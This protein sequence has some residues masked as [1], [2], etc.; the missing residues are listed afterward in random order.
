PHVG[1]A[2]LQH[3]LLAHRLWRIRSRPCVGGIFFAALRGANYRVNPCAGL[4]SNA[5]IAHMDLARTT[6]R[7][8]YNPSERINLS[9]RSCRTGREFCAACTF[10]WRKPRDVLFEWPRKLVSRRN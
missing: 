1:L 5:A 3:S 7:I 10:P 4:G 2:K 8:F 9:S 6:S